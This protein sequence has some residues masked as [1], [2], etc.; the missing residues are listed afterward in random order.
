MAKAAEYTDNS[1][2]AVICPGCGTSHKFTR[3]KWTFN[4]DLVQ[5][6]FAPSML[7]TFRGWQLKYDIDVE[8]DAVD[9][10]C[11]SFVTDGR[12]TFLADSTHHLAGQTVDLPDIEDTFV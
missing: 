3:G 9:T 8:F 5:P 10:V 4:G 1:G 6:T 7:T 11:H 2:W 12:I